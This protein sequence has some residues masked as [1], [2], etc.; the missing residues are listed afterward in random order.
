MTGQ[1][2]SVCHQHAHAR[3]R[4]LAA[5]LQHEA[6]CGLGHGG[7]RRRQNRCEDQEL[8]DSVHF[9]YR[10]GFDFLSVR[11]EHDHGGIVL[12]RQGVRFDGL[13]DGADQAGGR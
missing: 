1:Q 8:L 9:R 3:R 4:F 10:L 12:R 2:Q 13:Q 7:R 6:E 5:L 11:A